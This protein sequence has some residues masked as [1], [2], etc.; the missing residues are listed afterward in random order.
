MTWKPVLVAF[1]VA[2]VLVAQAAD[3]AAAPAQPGPAQA[4]RGGRGGP[5]VVSPQIE[6]DGRVTFRI[7]A[8]NATSVTVGG[9]INGSL[10]PDPAAKP[11]A[12]HAARRGT[13]CRG[14]SRR[15]RESAAG[16][17]DDQG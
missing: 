15:I 2:P 3:Q 13:G 6:P 14:S 11:L 7:L 8:P 1:I 16:R 17:P 12:R 10:V 4:A 5:I 9:D